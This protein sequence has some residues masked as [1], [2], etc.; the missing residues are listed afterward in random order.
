TA[1]GLTVQTQ[2]HH[3]N[4]WGRVNVRQRVSLRVPQSVSAHVDAVAGMVKMVAIDGDLHVNDVAVALTVDRVGGA[5]TVND[6]A[7]SV[8]LTVGQIGSTG[9][10][11]NDIAG[12]VDLVIDASA[13]ADI[14][15][16]DIAG[17]IDIGVA[18]VS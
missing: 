18:N 13:N 14:D 4:D 8:T 2:P 15:V 1:T 9:L 3:G 10:R 17:K 12:R 16:T 5:S 6:I 11:I 7:G